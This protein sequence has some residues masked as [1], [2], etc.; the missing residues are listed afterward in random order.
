MMSK[1]QRAAFALKV[2]ANQQA[3]E[4]ELHSETPNLTTLRRLHMIDH[5]QWNTVALEIEQQ[6]QCGQGTYLGT[7]GT[8]HPDSGG[9]SKGSGS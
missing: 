8:V 2:R 9:T 1:D 5:H 4:A 7:P 3:I 6:D